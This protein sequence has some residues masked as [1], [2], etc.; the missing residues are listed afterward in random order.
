MKKFQFRLESLLRFRAFGERMAQIAVAGAQ[1]NIREC[2][3]SIKQSE[4]DLVFTAKKLDTEMS[5]G[6]DANR[7][8]WYTSY[9]AGIETFLEAE[10]KRLEKLLKILVEKQK[11]LAQKSMEK[12]VMGNLKDRKKEEYYSDMVK[13]IQKETDDTIIIR[14]AR[15]INQ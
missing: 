2:E 12:K 9:I 10:R 13:S 5:S 11:K 15:D 6:I 1:L 7:Y 4:K 3:A 8:Q 14:K